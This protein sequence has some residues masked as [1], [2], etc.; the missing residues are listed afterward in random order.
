M[1]S[2]LQETISPVQKRGKFTK[3]VS[4]EEKREVATNSKTCFNNLS[5]NFNCFRYDREEIR[6][7]A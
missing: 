5:I 4:Q 6:H 3:D 2:L 1:K 7:I